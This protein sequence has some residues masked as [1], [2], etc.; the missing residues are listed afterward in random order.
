MFYPSTKKNIVRGKCLEADLGLLQHPSGALCDD[1]QR[2][3]AVN[4][5]HKALHLGCCSNPRSASD[6]N[7]IADVVLTITSKSY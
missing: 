6:A 3:P 1:S 4:Y 5:Y 2:L 7:A